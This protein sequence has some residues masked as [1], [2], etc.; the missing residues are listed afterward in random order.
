MIGRDEPLVLVYDGAAERRLLNNNGAE[1]ESGPDL[2]E[3]NVR[4]LVAFRTTLSFA[5]G[6]F[7]LLD[8]VIPHLVQHFVSESLSM[9]LGTEKE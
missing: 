4:L 8:F 9:Q 7:H 3:A 2:A 1:D 6:L 5:L